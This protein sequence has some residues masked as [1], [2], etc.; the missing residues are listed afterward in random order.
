MGKE[1]SFQSWKGQNFSVKIVI[2][3]KKIEIDD[4]D[5]F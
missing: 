2:H 3:G 1:K 4:L 5:F